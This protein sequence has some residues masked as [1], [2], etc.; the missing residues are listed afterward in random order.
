[1]S[2]HVADSGGGIDSEHLSRIFDRFYRVD[3]SRASPGAGLGLAIAQEIAR[4]HG[5]RIEVSSQP[6][7]GS[8]FTV[9]LP[10]SAT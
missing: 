10:M 5:G 1:V 3:P 7:R 9:S 4:S 2:I 6:G 8:R